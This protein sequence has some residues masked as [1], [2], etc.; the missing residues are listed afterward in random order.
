[1]CALL[2]QDNNVYLRL[3]HTHRQIIKEFHKMRRR[4]LH[5][6]VN[7][8]CNLSYSLYSLEL[9][10]VSLHAHDLYMEEYN[11]KIENCK[12]LS[13]CSCFHNPVA[14]K[15]FSQAPFSMYPF[16]PHIFLQ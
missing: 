11:K 4:E 15:P 6:C 3:R 10:N 12:I 9:N 7:I 13:K 5:T 14:Q 2:A 1:M 16:N 8:F